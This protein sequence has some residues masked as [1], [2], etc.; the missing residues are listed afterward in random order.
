M[1]VNIASLPSTVTFVTGL[2]CTRGLAEGAAWDDD[3]CKLE[4]ADTAVLH[5][6]QLRRN[7]ASLKR[8]S[9]RWPTWCVDAECVVFV[10]F[11]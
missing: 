9:V 7:G 6:K 5:N 11:A 4:A 10:F 1:V 2:A 3:V 8:K